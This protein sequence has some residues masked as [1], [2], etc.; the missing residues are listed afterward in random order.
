MVG[1]IIIGLIVASM[2]AMAVQTLRLGPLAA[3]Q[4]VQGSIKKGGG[5]DLLYKLILE[6]SD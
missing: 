1:G 6:K 5:W 2:A 4:P 3:Y